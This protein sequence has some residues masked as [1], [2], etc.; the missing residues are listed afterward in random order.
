M[1]PARMTQVFYDGCGGPEVL[2]VGETAVPRPGEGQV[3]VAVAAAGVN[4]PDILQRTGAYPPPKG[5]SEV[6]GLEVSGRVAA[7]GANVAGLRE[8]D[9]VCA[10]L[11][12]GGYAGYALADAALCLPRPAALTLAQ[13]GGLPETLFTV[14]DNVVTRGGLKAGER[15]LVHGGSSGI[16]TV[17]IQ[18]AKA[19]GAEVFAT[20]RPASTWCST[21]SAARISRR[22]FR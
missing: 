11:G 16:G 4:R 9:E 17:A 12:S 8:G 3:L 5:E 10:L 22:T 1:L 2:R 7:L 21:W 19:I 15:F 13:A 14:F 18:L 6:P 20:G